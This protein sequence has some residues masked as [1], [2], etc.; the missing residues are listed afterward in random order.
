[1]PKTLI[2]SLLLPVALLLG[3]PARAEENWPQFRGPTGQG[4]SDATGLPLKWSESEGV[5]W[6]TAIHDKGW[7][8]PVVL[9][10]QIWLTTA[11][12]DGR[13]LFA[14][15]VDR[16]TGKILHD[17]KLFEVAAPQYADKFN[18]YGSPTP[19]L[20]EG[21]VY[22][23][24]GSSGTACLD[25]HTGRTLW[26]RRD[27]PCN[28]WRGAGSSPT[29]WRNL[30]IL[31]FDGAD[32]QYV[33]ALDKQDGHTVWKTD[34]SIDFR[35]L[36][37]EGKP[38]RDGDFRKAFSSPLVIMHEGKPLLIS[39]GS[40]ATY[41]YDPATGRELWRVE[42]RKNH[43]GTVRPVV[44]HGMVFTATGLAKG[45]LWAVKLGG[46]GVVTDTHVAWKVTTHVPNRP[47][48]LLVGELLFMVHQD[49]GVVSCLEAMTGKLVWRERL[50]GI[51]NHSASPI[52]A[53]GR[54]YFFN[55][56]GHTAVIAASRQFK[57][58]AENK[59]DDGFMASPAVAGKALFLRTKTHLYRIESD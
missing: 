47:S 44:G 40:N 23:S 24:F 22:V 42:E 12:E 35:D 20:E 5:K 46:E 38:I 52:H 54:I 7:S 16:T 4:L 19:V 33:V 27:L 51:G 17:R 59:L 32:Y 55:E 53:E 58:L 14:I 8:S 39:V 10:N 11:T 18:S 34:R 21:R 28:H 36:T 13:E 56:N 31:H 43:S 3:L 2:S 41:C 50:P 9:G 48:P 15:A 37:P 26:E 30:L 6:K 29:V 57:V 25:T 45:E 1:M 49:T